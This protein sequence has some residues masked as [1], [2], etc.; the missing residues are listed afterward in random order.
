MPME[1]K[2]PRKYYVF[3]FR[4]AQ[5]TDTLVNIT[6]DYVTPTMG[7]ALVVQQRHQTIF[8]LLDNSSSD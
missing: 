7:V 6:V 8:L 5:V 3:Y 4:H 1:L 2:H